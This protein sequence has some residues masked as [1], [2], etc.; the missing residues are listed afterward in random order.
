MLKLI[1]LKLWSKHTYNSFITK[2]KI[3]GKIKP[4]QAKKYPLFLLYFI[5]IPFAQTTAKY[6]SGE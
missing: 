4:A 3:C 5:V 2:G 6:W 1:L